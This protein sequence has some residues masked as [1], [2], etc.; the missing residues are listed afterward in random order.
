MSKLFESAARLFTTRRTKSRKADFTRW[1]DTRAG[2]QPEMPAENGAGPGTDQ[3]D[4][5]CESRTIIGM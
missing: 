4:R 1:S 3:G 5:D 2:A